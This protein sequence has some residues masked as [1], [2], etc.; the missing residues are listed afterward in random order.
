MAV[1]YRSVQ[2]RYTDGFCNTEVKKA[3]SEVRTKVRKIKIEREE[4]KKEEK[5]DR[6]CQSV[7]HCE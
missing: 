3:R 1:T 5:E 4:K 7:F 6:R 2:I